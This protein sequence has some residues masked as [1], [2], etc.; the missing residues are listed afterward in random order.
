MREKT[1]LGSIAILV[2]VAIV[3]LLP[4][5]TAWSQGEADDVSE[6]LQLLQTTDQG[7]VEALGAADLGGLRPAL[8]RAITAAEQAQTQ[9]E[10]IART[11]TV[12]VVR[13]SAIAAFEQLSDALEQLREARNLDLN[14]ARASV[15][16]ARL[17]VANAIDALGPA[18]ERVRETPTPV[19]A[20]PTPVPPETP[21]VAATATPVAVV[22]E[23]LPV[24][25]SADMQLAI[26]WLAA[27][28]AGML[29][30]GWIVH[31]IRRS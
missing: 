14:E 11:T 8:D 23:R 20:T 28:G 4:V 16:G 30:G 19:P 1:L 6:A 25:G 15:V 31:R 27:S 10:A 12:P 22:V 17:L 13:A 5:S 21:V 9:L 26:G 24:G 7:L 18:L 29:L 2:I 3:T